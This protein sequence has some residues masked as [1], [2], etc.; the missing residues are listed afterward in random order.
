MSPS[1]VLLLQPDASDP[2]GPLGDWLEEAGL[3]LDHRRCEEDENPER[4]GDYAGLV[5]LGGTMS[6][7]DDGSYPWLAQVR[8]LLAASVT[9]EVPVLAICL[10]AQLLAVATGG[11]VRRM[12]EGPEVGTLLLAKR[13]AAS[14]DP[15]FAELPFTPDV[16]QFHADE[17]SALPPRAVLMASSPQCT[18]QAFRVG[19]MAYGLQC[20]IET[21]PDVVLGWAATAPEHARYARTGHL[22]AERLRAVH[23]DIEEVWRPFV[24]RF[25]RLVRRELASATPARSLP[26]A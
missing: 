16:I 25:A 15:L 10:G 6:A 8:R 9:G 12:P 5:V 7:L 21:T 1:T 22:E 11:S 4:P 20:H 17:V 23:A 18:Y 2:P 24:L 13:D 19:S 3:A 26:L 14:N